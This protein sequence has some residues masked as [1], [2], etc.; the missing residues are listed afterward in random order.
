[1]GEQ[2]EYKAMNRKYSEQIQIKYEIQTAL[3]KSKQKEATRH[4][5]PFFVSTDRRSIQTK[6]SLMLPLSLQDQGNS[7]QQLDKT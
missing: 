6:P 3:V 5:T 7:K 1:M 4:Q 2:K